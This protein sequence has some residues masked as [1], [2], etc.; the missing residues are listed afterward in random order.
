MLRSVLRQV[1]GNQIGKQFGFHRGKWLITVFILVEIRR[2]HFYFGFHYWFLTGILDYGNFRNQTGFVALQIPGGDGTHYGWARISVTG[3]DQLDGTVTLVDW[4]YEDQAGKGIKCGQ[5]DYSLPVELHSFTANATPEGVKLKWVTESEVDNLGFILERARV[6]N[7]NQSS[8]W[9]KITSYKTNVA[10]Q[11]GGNTSERR[12]YYFDDVNVRQGDT[13]SYRLSEVDIH[14]TVTVK[15]IIVITVDAASSI[16]GIPENTELLPA[17]PN[18]FNPSTRIQY[19]LSEDIPVT[20]EIIDILGRKVMTLLDHVKQSAGAYSVHWNGVTNT[21]VNAP[22][23]IYLI[24]L[25]TGN[26]LDTQKI[27]LVR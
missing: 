5:T 27:M 16:F 25:H 6:E 15:D 17:T 8:D 24:M 10:L 23:G 4:A 22:S 9:Y 3:Y 19:K 14:G 18:P 26:L 7:N 2:L 20:L 21:G 12:T 11:S 13:W 1:Q